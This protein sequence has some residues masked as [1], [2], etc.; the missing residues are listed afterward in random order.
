VGLQSRR[1]VQGF[2]FS[3]LRDHLES[4]VRRR[5]IFYSATAARV[6]E[7]LAPNRPRTPAPNSRAKQVP[8]PAT[9]EPDRSDDEEHQQREVNKKEE[10]APQPRPPPVQL[11]VL[12]KR[13][14]QETPSSPSRQQEKTGESHSNSSSSSK[15][16]SL[17]ALFNEMQLLRTMV[18]TCLDMQFELQRSVRQEV[19]AALSGRAA[20]SGAEQ[21]PP[22]STAAKEGLCH[23]CGEA[24]AD[25]VLYRCGHLCCCLPCGRSLQERAKPCPICHAP[26]VDVVRVCK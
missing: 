9:E 3:G 2:L 14:Q 10:T 21:S 13:Q 17:E 24:Q 8:Q 1:L 18:S 26:V 15:P 23:M 11:Q 20:A 6:A 12:A 16:L 25:T 4:M 7:A 19:A 22:T 5:L